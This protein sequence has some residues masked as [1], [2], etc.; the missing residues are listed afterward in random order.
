MHKRPI[1]LAKLRTVPHQFSWVDQRLVRERYI[2][3]LS[4]EACALYLFLV[5]VADAQGLSF[6]A[7]RSL[8][9]ALVHDPSGVTPGATGACH[10]CLGGLS[11]AL[12]TRSWLSI[13]TRCAPPLS[14]RPRRATT[15]PWTSKR[16]SSRSGRCCHD[17]LSPLLPDQTPACPPGTERLADRQSRLP[18]SPHGGLLAR[19]RALPPPQAPARPQ[20]NSIHSNRTLSAC[21]NAIPIRPRRSSSACAST[22]LPAAMRW[23]KP[24]CAPCDPAAGRLSHAGLCPR[25]VCPGRLGLVRLCP[26]GANAPPA[27]F[28]CH[29]PVLQPHA[30]RRVHRLPDDGA[31]SRLPSTRL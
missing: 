27:E 11:D 23:S 29:G 5:T 17:R 2:D 15:N 25:R 10:V 26:R 8:C 16:C 18:R 3:Q 22:A 12:S 4:P 21:W 24:M 19:P 9:A 31:L 20:A 1:S 28:L 30:V 7:D 14:A 6:Y 13:E